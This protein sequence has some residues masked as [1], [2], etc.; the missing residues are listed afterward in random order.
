MIQLGKK[1]TTWLWPAIGRPTLRMC[2][3]VL[4]G[5]GWFIASSQLFLAWLPQFRFYEQW[6]TNFGTNDNDTFLF[7]TWVPEVLLFLLGIMWASGVIGE[8]WKWVKNS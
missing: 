3:V 7:W 6:I 5:V 4:V 1:K 2:V 8:I